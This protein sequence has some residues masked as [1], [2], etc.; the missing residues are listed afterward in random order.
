MCPLL[1]FRYRHWGVRRP[2]TSVWSVKRLPHRVLRPVLSLSVICTIQPFG[3][4]CVSARSEHL[5]EGAWLSHCF[6]DESSHHHIIE[7][8][9]TSVDAGSANCID[10]STHT[11][12]TG[13]FTVC[14]LRWSLYLSSFRYWPHRNVC[15]WLVL[16][17]LWPRE[18]PSKMCKL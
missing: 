9:V 1:V 6:L 5:C 8:Q 12:C 13:M 17:V 11:K 2:R 4:G 3:S 15:N 7:Y 10:Q 18:S 16:F 14:S